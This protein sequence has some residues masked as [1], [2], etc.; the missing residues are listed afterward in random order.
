MGSVS[1]IPTHKPEDTCPISS[2]HV[3]RQ[4]WW[5]TLVIP[6]KHWGCRERRAGADR[7]GFL[8]SQP[9]RYWRVQGQ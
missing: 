1:E 6:E 8:A 5:Y 3:Q 9:I 7:Y 2:A 4:V